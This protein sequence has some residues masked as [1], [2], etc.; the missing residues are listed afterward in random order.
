MGIKSPEDFYEKYNDALDYA[1]EIYESKDIHDTSPEKKIADSLIE[2]EE[3]F[4]DLLAY[5]EELEQTKSE[6]QEE[7]DRTNLAYGHI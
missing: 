6:K 1:K 3:D 5:V 4:M 7:L 2:A